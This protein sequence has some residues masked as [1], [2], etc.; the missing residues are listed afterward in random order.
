M[1]KQS[2]FSDK[3]IDPENAPTISPETVC[4]IITKAHEFDVKDANTA[5]DPEADDPIGSVLEDRADDPVYDELKAFIS[6][7]T[8]DEQV[9]LVALA[10]LGREDY[11][12]EDWTTLR[13]DARS[14]HASYQKRTAANLL[15][16]PMLGDHLEEALSLFGKTCEADEIGWL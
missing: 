11:T 5:D 9:D 4:Y 12:V 16:M 2:K 3:Y 6:A 14:A 7:L 1:V 8:E 10:W 13:E 15:G